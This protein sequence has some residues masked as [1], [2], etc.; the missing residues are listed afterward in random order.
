[1]LGRSARESELATTNCP[2]AC[3]G[4][5]LL[6]KRPD[7]DPCTKCP[8]ANRPIGEDTP[9]SPSLS[10]DGNGADFS[11]NELAGRL[12]DVAPG[13]LPPRLLCGPRSN[14]SAR[15]L[16]PARA[17]SST[18]KR[19]PAPHDF[20]RCRNRA[21]RTLAGAPW[22]LSRLQRQPDPQAARRELPCAIGADPRTSFPPQP[23]SATEG[24]QPGHTSCTPNEGLSVV[25]RASVQERKICRTIKTEPRAEIG[26]NLDGQ[27]WIWVAAVLVSAA[28]LAFVMAFGRR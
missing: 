22:A 19:R 18:R 3:G 27:Q 20:R 17:P 26:A 4:R 5:R 13:T 7:E 28:T 11:L 9:I 23:E 15:A 12:S 24:R 8:L 21:S 16:T 2:I 1:M 10:R 6:D 14:P 25:L